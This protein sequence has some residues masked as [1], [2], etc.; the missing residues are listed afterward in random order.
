MAIELKD[1]PEP[2]GKWLI[3]NAKK[4]F[5]TESGTYYHYVEV[6]RLLQL[7]KDECV[8]KESSNE[9]GNCN[10]PHVMWRS[11]QPCNCENSDYLYVENGKC[12]CAN[13]GGDVSLQGCT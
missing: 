12:F 2:I 5:P 3:E 6:C 4:S 13:C 9:L 7:M 10:K 11:G 1:I 8:R